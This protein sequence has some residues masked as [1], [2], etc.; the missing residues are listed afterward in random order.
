MLL[1]LLTKFMVVVL[2]LSVGLLRVELGGPPNFDRS[3]SLRSY[4]WRPKQFL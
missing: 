2:S 1:L 3:E 4:Q